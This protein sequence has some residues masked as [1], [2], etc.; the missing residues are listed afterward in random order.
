MDL[1]RS[2]SDDDMASADRQLRQCGMV[3]SRTVAARKDDDGNPGDR[4]LWHRPAL[5]QSRQRGAVS[6]VDVT[7]NVRRNRRGNRINQPLLQLHPDLV[8]PSRQTIE[9]RARLRLAPRH[10][11]RS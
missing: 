5:T 4:C 3:L 7:D 2:T 6:L 8:K 11:H 9:R 10:L 1:V